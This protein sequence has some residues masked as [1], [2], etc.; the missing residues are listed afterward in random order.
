MGSRE[1]VEDKRCVCG[2]ELDDVTGHC[3]VDP[4]HGITVKEINQ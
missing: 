1:I 3:T 4:H 2:G